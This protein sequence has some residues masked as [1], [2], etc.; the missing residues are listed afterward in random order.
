MKDKNWSTKAG[1]AA[2][3]IAELIAMSGNALPEDYLR[4]L[5]FSNG[6]EGPLSIQPFWLV[7]D[8]AAFVT[9]TLLDGTLSEF[10]PGLVVIGSNGAGEAIAFDFRSGRYSCGGL[11]RHDEL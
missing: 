7:L 8:S 1:A 5:R 6:G 4:F 9:S 2:A 10:F 3:D 11:L